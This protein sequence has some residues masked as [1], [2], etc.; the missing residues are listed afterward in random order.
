MFF[1]KNK[2]AVSL[3]EVTIGALIFSISAAG[4]FSVFRAQRFATEQTE[5]RLEAAYVA[6]QVLED[7]RTKVDPQTWNTGALT[8]GAHTLPPIP[9]SNPL[10]TYNV[11]YNVTE[12]EAGVDIRRVDLTVTW[13]TWN[14]AP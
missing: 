4:L 3:I 13:T 8:L 10:V 5:N 11:T 14:D 6:R 2:K 1:L 9:S 7:L 12:P